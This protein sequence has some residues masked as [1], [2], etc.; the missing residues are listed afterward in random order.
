MAWL[1]L[2]A[3]LQGVDLLSSSIRRS[4]HCLPPG[5]E[6]CLSVHNNLRFG[7]PL[8]F[9]IIH[10]RPSTTNKKG[11]FP[12][13]TLTILGLNMF[14]TRSLVHRLFEQVVRYCDK[15]LSMIPLSFILGF[16]V[17]IIGMFLTTREI[18]SGGKRFTEF[19]IFKNTLPMCFPL[20]NC[21]GIRHL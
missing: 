5:T 18:F 20:I 3:L 16:Y 4:E 9:L 7:A 17:T 15:Y 21:F 13:I 6:S 8:Y 12:Y 1:S 11:S 19:Q 14:F 2:Q 10:C